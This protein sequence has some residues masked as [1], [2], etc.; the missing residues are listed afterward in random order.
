VID[1]IKQYQAK[2]LHLTAKQSAV[3]ILLIENTIL[4]LKRRSDL[5]HYA[6]QW[7]LPGGLFEQDD[8]NLLQTAWRELFEETNIQQNYCEYIGCLDDFYNSQ[9]CL[10]RPYI[11]KIDRYSFEQFFKLQ[12]QE[13]CD[14]FLLPCE[15]LED[16]LMEGQLEN[17]IT[18]RVPSYY[19]KISDNNVIWGLTSAILAHLRD[20]MQKKI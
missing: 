20:I 19:Y 10:V 18:Y 7:C 8:N 2:K 17:I 3:F 14:F 1:L 9:N 16:K 13:H 6:G 11:A 4:C 5:R 15:T 12:M